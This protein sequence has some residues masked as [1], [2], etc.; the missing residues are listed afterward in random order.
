MHKR[1][2]L[3]AGGAAV[4]LAAIAG[5]TSPAK[6]PA[7]ATGGGAVPVRLSP[8]AEIQAA[9]SKASQDKTVHVTGTISSPTVNGTVDAREQFAREYL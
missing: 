5:C 2:G 8:V 9:L 4:A 7:G 6:S 1:I 3:M